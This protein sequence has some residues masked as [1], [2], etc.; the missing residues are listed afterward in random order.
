MLYG[1]YSNSSRGSGPMFVTLADARWASLCRLGCEA[2]SAG[3]WLLQSYTTVLSACHRRLGLL[4]LLP[5]VPELSS[6][7]I[8]F[9]SY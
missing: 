6:A 2:I 9:F 4:L 7:S 8:Y 1:L 5:A 3:L